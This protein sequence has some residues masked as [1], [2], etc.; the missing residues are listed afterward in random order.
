M[1]KQVIIE[2]TDDID[3]SVISDNDGESIDFSVN[4]VDYTIDLKN[5][6]AIE[7]HRKFSYYT[8]R[9]TR[10]GGR[11]HRSSTVIANKPLTD[12]IPATR[13]PAQ[14]RAIREWANANGYDVSARGRI[15]AA[16]AAAFESAH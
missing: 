12:S 16:V 5:K 10:V 13:D 9:A 11:K 14:T 6:N 15:P 8:D 4:G 1:A 7:F 3:G 2:L